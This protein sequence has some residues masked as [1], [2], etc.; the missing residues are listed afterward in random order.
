[1]VNIAGAH[2]GASGDAIGQGNAARFNTPWGLRGREDGTVIVTDV[3]NNAVRQLSVPDGALTTGVGSSLASEPVQVANAS[4]RYRGTDGP[5]PF[6]DYE[7]ASDL[8]FPVRIALPDARR[9]ASGASTDAQEWWFNVPDRVR[10]FSF[11][12]TVEAATSGKASPEGTPGATNPRVRVQ[13]VISVSPH[14]GLTPLAQHDGPAEQATISQTSTGMAVAPD[15]VVYLASLSTVR[16]YDPRTNQITTIAGAAGITGETVGSG[17][18][19]S[20][21]RL[22]Y[23]FGITAPRADVVFVG[24]FVTARIYALQHTSGDPARASNWTVSSI[25]GT[26]VVGEPDG[27]VTSPIGRPYSLASSNEHEIW[28]ADSNHRVCLATRAS[29]S[30][31]ALNNWLTTV[32]AGGG[33][34]NTDDPPRFNT[35]TGLVV[36]LDRRLYVADRHNSKIRQVTEDIEV[37]TVAGAAGGSSPPGYVDGPAASA[38]FDRPGGIARDSA[39]YLYVSDMTGIRRISPAGQVTTVLRYK[40]TPADGFGPAAAAGPFRGGPPA[41]LAVAPDGDIWF[42]DDAGLRRLSRVISTGSP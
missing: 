38:R 34:G 7:L 10:A 30:A 6:F 23:A 41:N 29:D 2:D 37:S 4:G 21:A 25:I 12:A 40:A 8:G 24:D 31:S 5:L 27:T 17:V 3:Q 28:F 36:G 39:N 19:G 22:T 20:D 16:R 42:I 1:M 33:A 32:V 18:S 11:I 15:G 14:G 35:I 26:G 13:T 9:L